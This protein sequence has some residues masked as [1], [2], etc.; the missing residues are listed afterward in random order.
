MVII[1]SVGSSSSTFRVL[2]NL[3]SARL[4]LFYAVIIK[5]FMDTFEL[6]NDNLRKRL[7]SHQLESNGNT[8]KVHQVEFLLY[9]NLTI[10]V[11]LHLSCY[12]IVQ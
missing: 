6:Q 8:G 1:F 5:L 9:I 12:N 2:V 11:Y 10:A 3:G 7:E 4:V